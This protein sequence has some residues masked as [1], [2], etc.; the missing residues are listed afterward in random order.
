MADCNTRQLT[1]REALGRRGE[2]LA[3]RLLRGAGYRILSRNWRAG[4]YE[5]D[6]VGQRGDEVVF[7][8]V[9]TRRPGPQ[10][11]SESISPAQR[12]NLGRAAAAWMRMHPLVGRAFRFDLVAI[13]WPEGEGP[14]VQYIPAAFDAHGP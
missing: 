9:K 6:L 12:R 14:R 1:E 10:S 5:I 11:A 4:R 7:V 8:E 3:S 2:D 13:T